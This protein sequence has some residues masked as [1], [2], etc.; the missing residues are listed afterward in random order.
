VQTER[1]LHLN[2]N[3]DAFQTPFARQS[4]DRLAAAPAQ[5]TRPSRHATGKL[6]SLEYAEGVWRSAMPDRSVTVLP[7]RRGDRQQWEVLWSLY[8]ATFGRALPA[9]VIAATW[10][11][12]HDDTK[13]VYGLAAWD[14]DAMVGMTL[15]LVHEATR[16]IAPHCYLS[17]LFT[18][19]R[20]RRRGVAKNLVMAAREHAQ[21]MG[22]ERIYW[23]THDTNTAARPLYDAIA[24]RSGL[25][26]YRIKF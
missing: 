23:M 19:E 17:V 21:R 16:S 8:L 18:A 3:N 12:I 1:S 26:E 24:E 2:T 5:A 6:V 10:D 9:D 25:I 4:T 22:C 11:K 7:M 13:P 20:A 15:Y 14:G